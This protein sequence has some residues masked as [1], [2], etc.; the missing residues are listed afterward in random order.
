MPPNIVF[1]CAQHTGRGGRN[2]VL[3]KPKAGIR[4][5][6]SRSTE[7]VVG[8][9]LGCSPRQQGKKGTNNFGLPE[10]QSPMQLETKIME[11]YGKIKFATTRFQMQ[12]NACDPM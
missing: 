8:R 11:R 6:K 4:K 10:H 5:D 2:I 1:P 7:K 12:S 3:R 9:W